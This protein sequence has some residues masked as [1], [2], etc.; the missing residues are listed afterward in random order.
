MRVRW[1]LQEAGVDFE[2]IIVDLTKGEQKMPE[3]LAINPYGKLPVL[4]DNGR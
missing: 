4:E 3:F 1:V 2:S